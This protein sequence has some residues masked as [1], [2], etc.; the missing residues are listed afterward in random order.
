MIFHPRISLFIC[1]TAVSMATGRGADHLSNALADPPKW[2][3]LEKFQ[4][5]ITHDQFEQLLRDVYCTRGLSDDYIRIDPDAACILTD[6]D[7]QTW[8]KL[9]FAKSE[10]DRRPPIHKWRP[11]QSLPKATKAKPLLGIRIALDPGHIG[12]EWARMEERWFKTDDV[13]PVEEGEMTLKVAKMAATRLAE[14]GA[15]VSF[16]RDKT[17]PVTPYRPADFRETA[18]SI[19]QANGVENPRENFDDSADPGKE[20][21]VRWQSE[22]LFYRTSEIRERARRVNMNLHPDLV[23]CL[24]FNAEAWGDER[25]PTLSEKNHLH[26]LVNGS[27]LPAELE[28]DDERF[29]MLQRLLSRTYDEELKIADT[30]APVVAK[31]TGLPAYQYTTD[32]VVKVGT[33]GYVYARN[34]VATRLYECPVVYFEP[35]VMNSFDVVAR[36]KAGDYDGTQMVNG[37]ERVSIYREY[38]EGVVGGLLEYYKTA[39]K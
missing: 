21:T 11:A 15:R 32:N 29:E 36:I 13:P 22:L 4:R 37:V 14:L 38:V 33:S 19:L 1:L 39:R 3:T 5:T 8:F 24:H 16:V 35:Y 7:R 10:H 9:R 20:Q 23:L 25:N 28:F 27:Y 6:R 26:L 17:E 34:L 2:K 31:V 12:G 18:R 30:A